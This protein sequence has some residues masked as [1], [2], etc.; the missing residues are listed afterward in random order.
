M[1]E[2]RTLFPWSQSPQ[3]M[4][5]HRR[6]EEHRIAH[7]P[8]PS[9]TLPLPSASWNSTLGSSKAQEHCQCRNSHMGNCPSDKQVISLFTPKLHLCS[10][11]W[12]EQLQS[13]NL[14]V[15][16]SEGSLQNV[17]LQQVGTDQS[18][19]PRC[20]Y[21]KLLQGLVAERRLDPLVEL[22][23]IRTFCN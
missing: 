23:Q 4:S 19:G 21:Q 3:Q 15:S 9:S 22:G 5:R 14:Q 8:F 6:R 1:L 12:Q 17:S 10:L 16:F 11:P 2:C 18:A 13:A 20:V 7:T